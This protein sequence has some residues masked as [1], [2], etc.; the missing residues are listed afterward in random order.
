MLLKWSMNP[1]VQLQVWPPRP[2][3]GFAT[4]RDPLGEAPCRVTI[5]QEE[6]HVQMGQT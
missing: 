4:S 1:N 6:T 2:R 5:P 3:P